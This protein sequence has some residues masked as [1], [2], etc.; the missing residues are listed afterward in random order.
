VNPFLVERRRGAAH[1]EGGGGTT[2]VFILD[3]RRKLHNSNSAGG[4]YVVGG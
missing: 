3:V 4:K 1:D 2:W